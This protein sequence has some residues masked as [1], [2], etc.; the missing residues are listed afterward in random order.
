[1]WKPQHD[2]YRAITNKKT[3]P[4]RVSTAVADPPSLPG[5]QHTLLL[6]FQEEV[7][8]MLTPGSATVMNRTERK[9]V[10][11]CCSCGSCLVWVLSSEC[12]PFTIV[13]SYGEKN[14]KKGL[15]ENVKKTLEELS[16]VI[17]WF[18]TTLK[19]LMA[20]LVRTLFF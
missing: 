11:F 20:S 17:Q 4:S 13:C 19:L 6:K 2:T 14:V 10:S 12:S 15:E 5:G 9:Q 18:T 16:Q 7:R 8:E 3:F 1:M